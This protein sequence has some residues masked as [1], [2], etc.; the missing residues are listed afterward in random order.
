MTR[1]VSIRTKIEQLQALVGTKDLSAWETKFVYDMRSYL[2][3][4]QTTAL[5]GK[6]VDVIERLWGKH[7]A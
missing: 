7:F 6:Q 1:L 5:S 2:P 3:P 4:G